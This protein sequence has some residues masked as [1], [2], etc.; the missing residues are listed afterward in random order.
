MP[1]CPILLPV[2]LSAPLHPSFR[3]PP[4]ILPFNSRPCLSRVLA[5]ITLI[6]YDKTAPQVVP[7]T[8]LCA[9]ATIETFRAM[10]ARHH[11]VLG[12]LLAFDRSCW[13][14]Q[15]RLEEETNDTKTICL[16]FRWCLR[17]SAGNIYIFIFIGE[18]R[19][20]S[21]GFSQKGHMDL[22]VSPGQSRASRP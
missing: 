11:G 15:T 2:A 4:S 19:R 18:R 5:R 10:S 3:S 16:G 22:F 13:A 8:D 1:Q 12:S 14:D 21:S 7:W 20:E 17:H 6:Q 9:S